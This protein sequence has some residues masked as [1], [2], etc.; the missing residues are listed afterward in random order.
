MSCLLQ[1]VEGRI[2]SSFW[3]ILY[4]SVCQG[5]VDQE[6]ENMD[7]MSQD[8]DACESVATVGADSGLI[9]N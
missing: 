8:C 2:E 3:G 7:L 5:V 9:V 1:E 4:G 6:W